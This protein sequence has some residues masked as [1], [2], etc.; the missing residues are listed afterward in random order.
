MK[1]VMKLKMQIYEEIYGGREK[2]TMEEPFNIFGRPISSS[3][4]ARNFCQNRNQE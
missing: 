2:E 3:L 1:Y 4:M